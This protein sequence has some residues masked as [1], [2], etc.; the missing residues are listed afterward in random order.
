MLT[1]SSLV[2]CLSQIACL[3]PTLLFPGKGYPLEWHSFFL[4]LF[5]IHFHKETVYFLL[6]FTSP[7]KCDGLPRFE[8]SVF[9]GR[10]LASPI[11]AT[12]C[13]LCTTASFHL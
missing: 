5:V 7:W 13:N 11:G 4:S 12:L 8:L 9:L 6:I 1:F 3:F 2:V 10:T